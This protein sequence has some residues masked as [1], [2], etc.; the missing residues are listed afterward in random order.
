MVSTKFI[1]GEHFVDLAS[2]EVF[3]APTNILIFYTRLCPGKTFYDFL[4][5]FLSIKLFNSMEMICTLL[6]LSHYSLDFKDFC[7]QNS[8]RLSTS[9]P[10]IV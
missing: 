4:A 1:L 3:V 7:K 9:H 2:K 6:L 5:M 10:D 8:I